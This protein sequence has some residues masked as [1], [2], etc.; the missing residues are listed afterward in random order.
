MLCNQS[1][2]LWIQMY[3]MTIL[4]KKYEMQMTLWKIVCVEYT[5]MCTK[6]CV[7]Y[8]KICVH[9]LKNVYIECTKYLHSLKNCGC[10]MSI[11]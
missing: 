11:C 2:N 8:L 3:I 4:F 6:K 10:T 9:Y 7:H 1:L 5:E